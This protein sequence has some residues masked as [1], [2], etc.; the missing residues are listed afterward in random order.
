MT[1]YTITYASVTGVL[2]D[3]DL[4]AADAETLINAAVDTLNIFGC[5]IPRLAG[6]AES[7]T[8]S[9]SS[10]ELGAVTA[11]TRVIYNSYWKNAANNTGVG[12]SS[13]SVNTADLMSNATTWAMIETIAGKLIT[14]PAAAAGSPPIYL[15]KDPIPY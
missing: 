7:M 6:T 8:A 4:E 10:A 14:V 12:L 3:D 9:W 13:L 15:S 2:N 5:D 1:D 11:V